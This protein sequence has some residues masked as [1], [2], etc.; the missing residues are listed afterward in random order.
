[1]LALVLLIVL[2]QLSLNGATGVPWPVKSE[3]DDTDD[4][5]VKEK[6]DKVGT[7]KEYIVKELS[8]TLE[9]DGAPLEEEATLAI[10]KRTLQD[11]DETI[12]EQVSRRS[13][14]EDQVGSRGYEERQKKKILTKKLLKALR[15]ARERRRQE[16][17][18]LQHNLFLFQKPQTLATAASFQD[19]LKYFKGVGH[20]IKEFFTRRPVMAQ[21]GDSED[22]ILSQNLSVAELER[23]SDQIAQRQEIEEALVQGIFRGILKSAVKGGRVQKRDTVNNDRDV[24]LQ[25][26]NGLPFVTQSDLQARHGKTFNDHG[27][28]LSAKDEEPA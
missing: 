3:S 2:S 23:E 27:T 5:R 15:K 7:H 21:D 1:M 26:M 18:L 22:S 28:A 4:G 12:D 20:R 14:V 16:K 9:Q 10:D 24:L 13:V 6:S 25:I 19:F 17:K 11:T 8:D